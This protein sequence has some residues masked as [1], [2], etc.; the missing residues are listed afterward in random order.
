[1][2]RQLS[3]R[4]RKA[5]A[6][7]LP[8]WKRELIKAR[9]LKHA[10]SDGQ[11]LAM[12]P[13]LV[14]RSSSP[15]S[16]DLVPTSWYP[17]VLIAVGGAP[18]YLLD[19]NCDCSPDCCAWVFERQAGS[20]SVTT[21]S[22]LSELLRAGVT[23][24][25]DES[26]A[27]VAEIVPD[28]A[29]QVVLLDLK[30]RS[31]SPGDPEDYFVTE[32]IWEVSGLSGSGSEFVPFDPGTGYY[33]TLSNGHSPLHLMLPLNSE[34]ALDPATVDDY[35]R[36]LRE[37]TRPTVV[38]ATMLTACEDPVAHVVLDGHHKLQAAAVTGVPIRVIA[39]VMPYRP[40]LPT[41]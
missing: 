37:G 12:R 3:W 4:D 21:K 16:L 35:A 26:V 34:D 33:R 22:A 23:G 17:D 5:A 14:T 20:G 41:V 19:V 2:R 31:V 32:R 18:I 13:W 25:D 11:V 27:A 38:S 1:M 39:F 30:V 36:C 28:G 29:Y 9:Q 40:T 10:L 6:R 15:V 8:V 24:L 7:L